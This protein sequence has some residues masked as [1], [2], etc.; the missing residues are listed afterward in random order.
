MNLHYYFRRNVISHNWPL[1]FYSFMPNYY[2][3]FVEWVIILFLLLTKMIAVAEMLSHRNAEPVMELLVGWP[4]QGS[5]G[6]SNAAEWPEGVEPGA[7]PSQT[8]FKFGSGG[9]WRSL[10]I[11]GLPKASSF[12]PS[13]LHPQELHL[14]LFSFAAI[15]SCAALLLLYFPSYYRITALHWHIYRQSRH[16]AYLKNIFI[17]VFLKYFGGF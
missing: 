9:L 17:Y 3:S 13:F 6:A 8:S 12:F 10:P 15:Y 11:W 14:S 2:R 4:T 1:L 16:L 5:S 7:T